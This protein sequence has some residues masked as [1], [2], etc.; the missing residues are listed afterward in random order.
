MII[1]S[2]LFR[3]FRDERCVY[4]LL[5]ACLGGELWSMLRQRGRL[6]EQEARFAVGC[7]VQ[8]VDYLHARSI[9]YRDLKPENLVLDARGYVKL[10]SAYSSLQRRQD[11]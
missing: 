10:V 6:E 9:I 11:A 4:F 8:A 7:V 5:E 3:T 2:R 1:S